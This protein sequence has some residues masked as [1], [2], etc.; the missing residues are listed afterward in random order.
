MKSMNIHFLK[1][2]MM[3]ILIVWTASL[4]AE[5]ITRE[6]AAVIVQDYIENEAIASC[7]LMTLPL[8]SHP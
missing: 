2:I 1:T 5:N 3:S 8:N 7:R 4:L 6:Q